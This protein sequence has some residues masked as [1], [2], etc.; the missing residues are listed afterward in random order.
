MK[1]S[2]FQTQA[3]SPQLVGYGPKVCVC[4]RVLH[5]C[6]LHTFMLHASVWSTCMVCVHVVCVCVCHLHPGSA[7]SA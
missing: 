5:A 3:A 1:P 2:C 7:F 4:L 6:S